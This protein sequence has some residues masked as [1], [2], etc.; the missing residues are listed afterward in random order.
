MSNRTL[1][2]DDRIYDYLVRVTLRESD[3]ARRLRAE[4]MQLPLARMQ[5]APE[6]AQFMGLLVELVGARRAIE[7]GTFTGYSALAVA[8]A[9]PDDGKLVACDLDEEWTAIGRRYWKESGVDHKIDLQL[10]PAIETLDELVRQ[11]QAGS[12]DFA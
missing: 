3:A 1:S 8:L 4:T 12:F 7:V 9:L 11:N 10:R 5:I 6:Q 2:V